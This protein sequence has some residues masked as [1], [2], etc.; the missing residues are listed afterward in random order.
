MVSLGDLPG[1][2]TN[3]AGLAVSPDG[4]IV[5]GFGYPGTFD[6]PYTQEACRWTARSGLVGLG[7][8]PGTRTSLAYGLSADGNRIVG[9]NKSGVAFLWEPGSG[10]R[11]LEGVLTNNFGIK[12]NGWKLT[13]ARG[14]SRDGSAIVG[15]GFNPQGQAEGWIVTGLGKTKPSKPHE[16]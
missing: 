10:M 9:D 12:L 16:N 7:F 1:G 6:D 4:S 5:I 11:L 8:P 2:V 14:I 13:S 3:S 15:A